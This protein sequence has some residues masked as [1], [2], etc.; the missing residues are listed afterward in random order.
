MAVIEPT[1]GPSRKG[2]RSHLLYSPLSTLPLVLSTQ[3]HSLFTEQKLSPCYRKAGIS[4]TGNG[5]LSTKAVWG[6]GGGGG[7]TEFHL[8]LM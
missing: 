1:L 7:G 6:L 2:H 4:P 5:A 3:S 8:L